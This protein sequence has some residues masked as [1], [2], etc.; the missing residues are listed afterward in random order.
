MNQVVSE[1]SIFVNISKFFCIVIISMCTEMSNE[2]DEDSL[3]QYDY[4]I[5][6]DSEPNDLIC[7]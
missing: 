5:D 6:G 7:W 3:S 4:V 1:F 2:E